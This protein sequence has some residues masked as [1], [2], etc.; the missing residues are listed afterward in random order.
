MS[1]AI[2]ISQHLILGHIDQAD[3][4][5][6]NIPQWPKLTPAVKSRSQRLLGLVSRCRASDKYAFI[7]TNQCG[8]NDSTTPSQPVSLYL[9][10]KQW[11]DSVELKEGL[12]VTFELRRQRGKSRHAAINV[13]A[14]APGFDDYQ[15][16]M[17][18]LTKFNAIEGSINRTYFHESISKLPQ[19][20]SLAVASIR[21]TILED[22]YNCQCVDANLWD[23]LLAN[24]PEDEIASFKFDSSRIKVIPPAL[25]ITLYKYC[26]DCDL[27]KNDAIISALTSAD[28]ASRIPIASFEKLFEAPEDKQDWAAYVAKS[29][30][31]S[32]SLRSAL[33]LFSLCPAVISTVKDRATFVAGISET[34]GSIIKLI[35]A[36]I[37]NEDSDALSILCGI[38]DSRMAD[39]LSGFNRVRLFRF[40]NALPIPIAAKYCSDKLLADI[41]LKRKLL[42]SDKGRE[43]LVERLYQM[44]SQDVS[45]WKLLLSAIEKSNSQFT[46][47]ESRIQPSAELRLCLYHH[48]HDLVWMSHPSI[49]EY[50][51]N[52]DSAD[53][54]S[55]VVDAF[56]N[57]KDYDQW[58][59]Y[60]ISSPLSNPT[61]LSQLFFKKCSATLYMAIEDKSVII[62]YFNKSKLKEWQA[63]IPFVFNNL[64][65]DEI[66]Q[67]C[68][69]LAFD[70]L[71]QALSKVPEA[72]CFQWI[73]KLSDDLAIKIATTP[74]FKGTSVFTN[75]IG[76]KWDSLKGQMEYIAFVLKSKDDNVEEFAFSCEDNIRPYKGDMQISALIRRLKKSPI[77]VGHNIKQHDLTLLRDR[78]L[79]L[80]DS[81]FIWDTLEMEIM[82]NPC[83]YAYS[84]QPQPEVE[85]DAKLV[86]DL[87]WNQLYRLS[88]DNE[89]VES[90][91]EVLPSSIN[92]ILTELRKDYF[93]SY[94]KQTANPDYK[95]FKE[96]KPLA[97]QTLTEL[98]AIADI[99]CDE[100]TLVI[101]PKSIWARLAQYIPLSFPS[102]KDPTM[103]LDIQKMQ[104]QPIN[105]EIKRTI[106]QRFCQVSKTPLHRNLAL[107]LRVPAKDGSP[108][109]I[110]LS[111]DFLQPY[112]SVFHSHIDCVDVTGFECPAVLGKQYKHIYTIGSE[113]DDRVHKRCACSDESLQNLIQRHSKLIF[114]MAATNYAPVKGKEIEKL[115]IVMPHLAANVWTER[116]RN[117]LFAFFLNYHYKEYRA[118]FLSHFN[119]APKSIK[120]EF[121]NDDEHTHIY[122]AQFN[123]QRDAD[124]L[125]RLSAST[126]MRTKYWAV[127]MMIINKIHL[128]NPHAPIIYI[129]N[130]DDELEDLKKYATS[131]GFYIPPEGKGLNKIEYTEG[132]SNCLIIITKNEFGESIDSFRT[133]KVCCFVWDNMDIDRYMLMWDKLPFVDDIQEGADAERDDT[134]HRSTPRQCIHALWPIYQ[135]YCSLVMAN[136]S[137]TKCFIIDPY[138]DDYE[139]IAD[140]CHTQSFKVDPQESNILFEDALAAASNFFGDRKVEDAEID[141]PFA[142][143]LIRQSFID[144]FNWKPTQQ[145]ILPHIIKKES[146]CIISM[147]TGEGKSVCFQGPALFRTIT[148]GK[149][150]LVITPL[151]ALMQDQVENLHKHGFVTN[152]DYISG[153]RQ[154]PEVDNIYRKIR[155]GELALLFITPERF[156][157]KS[158]I[159]VLI[160]RMEMDGGLEY[161][162]FDEAHCISQWGQDFRPDYRNAVI[163]CSELRQRFSFMFA[164]FSATVTSQVEEDIRSFLPHIQRLGQS[165]EDYNPIRQH[166]DISFSLVTHND[167][168]RVLEISNIIE[169]Q[170]ID[171]A[172]SCMIVFC[173]THRQCEETADALNNLAQIAAPGSILSK[174]ADRIGFYHAG[175]DSDLRNDVYEQFKQ[176]PGVSPIYILCA[177]KAFGMG[178]DIPNVHYV[179]HFNPPSVLEDYLQEVGRAGRD[180]QMYKTAF[181]N[182]GHIPAICL[183]SVEDFKKL[184][185]LLVRGQMSWSN[186]TEAKDAIVNYIKKFQSLEQTKTTPV[187]V[188][189]DVWLRNPDK[190]NDITPSRLAFHWLEKIGC[191]R[192][193]YLSPAHI[194]VT[195]CDT[196]AQPTPGAH[197]VY[198]YI[199][200][201][202]QGKNCL[203]SINDIRSKL[204]MSMPRIM[205]SLIRLMQD[206]LIQ[207]NENVTCSI[208]RSRYCE[209][210]DMVEKNRN[211]YTLHIIF[212]GIR[213]LLSSCKYNE[214]RAIGQHERND[215]FH[216]LM[217]EVEF[218]VI[219]EGIKDNGNDKVKVY[220]PWKS[221]NDNPP[222]RA[223]L[224]Y[225]TFRK[226]IITRMGPQ[227][228]SILYYL[229]MVSYKI[230]RQDDEV[231]CLITVKND[232]WADYLKELEQDCFQL[233]K[234]VNTNVVTLNW[235]QT[236]ID[237]G[238]TFEKSHKG[239]RYFEDVLSILQLLRYIDHSSL[240]KG[241][242]EILA[243][244]TTG[245]PI[246]EGTDEQ[247]P[248]HDHRKEFDSQ[249]QLRK[250]RLACMNI[251]SSVGAK[252]QGDYIRRYFQ[253]RNFEDYLK[254]AGDFLPENSSILSEV[255]EEALKDEE[256]KMDNN[257]QQKA[258]YNQP[259]DANVNVLAGPGSGKTY[260]L[261]LRCLKLIYK[262]HVD[263]SH[264]LVLAYNRAVV[265]ELRNRLNALFIRLGMSRSAYQLHVY[266]FHALAKK[267]L[268]KQ[269]DNVLTDKWEEKFLKHLT[270]K[271]A[272]FIAHFSNIAFVL[273]DEFQDITNV[274]LATL[275]RLHEIFNKAKFFTIGDINQSIYGFDRIP[276]DYNGRRASLQ[277]E[278]Y[279]QLLQ[280]QPYYDRWDELIKPKQLT[281]STN[282]RSYQ[283]ILDKASK[284]ITEGEMPRSAESLMQY[285]PRQPYVFEIDNTVESDRLWY[286]EL[287]SII[288]WAIEE[289]KAVEGIEDVALQRHRH[290][291][292]IAVFFRTNNEVY[293]GYSMIKDRIPSGARIRIQGESIGELWREREIFYLINIL[294]KNPTKSI[295]LKNNKTCGGIKKF[296]ED[297]MNRFTAWEPFLLDIT[298]CLVLNYIDSIRSDSEV[299]TWQDMADYIKDVASR[300]DATQVYKIYESYRAERILQEPIINIVLT[301]MHKV[302][303][304]EFDV[305]VTTPSDAS[306]PLVKHRD[307]QEGEPP[308]SDDL[309]DIEEERRLMYVAYTRAK[310][311]LYIYKSH[312]EIALENNQIY[313]A[314]DNNALRF[315]EVDPGSDKYYLNFSVTSQWFEAV[316]PYILQ[317]VKRDDPV[318]VKRTSDGNCYIMHNGGAIG[319]L[320]SGSSIAKRATIER[321]TELAGFFISSVF[322]WKYDDTLRS[323]KPEY[324]RY[325]SAKAIQN[326][327]VYVVQIA[328]FGKPLNNNTNGSN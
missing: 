282:Y 71:L 255:T 247:S 51:A 11:K 159:E 97:P 162:I 172:N 171:F 107:Y 191:I 82:L 39:T 41:Y 120:W 35:N 254:L 42:D 155:S 312:R 253:S 113:L 321:V 65:D 199:I 229:P 289:N 294:E 208:V 167:E 205:D 101:A 184:K 189:F 136:N 296:L 140:S 92:D 9:D 178:M 281:M 14:L 137:D 185:D 100:D 160:Q 203:I 267:C 123:A 103:S 116:R 164:L 197:P 220:M 181:A 74:L 57:L 53:N 72:T 259:K 141:V 44:Q 213:Q 148:S 323:K 276:K 146:D 265:V 237:L 328:G 46:F 29:E 54:I 192:Q 45:E 293:R 78:G 20:K 196:A 260:V 52:A 10:K 310:K 246:P 324:A 236:I 175:L 302:K 33:Y 188:P 308:L 225:D 76:E 135:H 252:Y 283:A 163:K 298:Y 79:D 271:P 94:F 31:V 230:E 284:F 85:D 219:K 322:V 275:T 56:N 206:K 179:V 226:N 4:N 109:K 5:L 86:N 269:L 273:V 90:L 227:M 18:Y 30:L 149:L 96:L 234:L 156:R 287:P 326:G 129:V 305:V 320:S 127:Q 2:F 84:L 105:D 307:Y 49:I 64:S 61:L 122:F 68:E 218:D 104:A 317:K 47:D 304:L 297:A 214:E 194:D 222:E 170:T 173:R 139:D 157:V 151:R 134:V 272:D 193:R 313:T 325:W 303:G 299:H 257:P 286:T 147:P 268:G 27:L 126:P 6:S 215:I 150:S 16:W 91:Q 118:Q 274:R 132:R 128:T 119:V 231:I 277:P 143:D 264:I 38:D 244:N 70:K 158:F 81:T 239:Y 98:Q 195:I 21:E 110:T 80:P 186:L 93:E 1:T 300:D 165:A 212:Q 263:P 228:F 209:L 19:S 117:G 67:L 311:R 202:P 233:L 58:S 295:E 28:E 261:T 177:T 131:L 32:D 224:L 174:C 241:G 216:H 25:L 8:I 217:D 112:L 240:S 168:A 77:I 83:R 26:K 182:G 115:D 256:K 278:R 291:D 187:V 89:L 245:L 111:E 48:S 7:V 87:F 124:K 223:V 125:M 145:E 152:V 121:C 22:L 266:T 249:E 280:P 36:Y 63:F 235:A 183:A 34:E 288:D 327:Y 301:T 258:I 130:D 292:T 319:R 73:S 316:N 15:V 285:Q 23:G 210:M 270:A 166:I 161:V 99:P 306:L 207:V 40:V 250:I 133:D 55:R 17:K 180:E 251:F 88:L 309:A 59:Q 243:T 238:W 13:R 318:I 102:E 114:A 198:K 314:P 62:N 154:R 201:Q 95:F 142:M 69:Q 12:W 315:T 144:G 204:H 108:Q 262:E 190:V 200:G 242:V 60:V 176:V 75:Y 169:Q 106:L 153:D 37:E 43:I 3:L 50:I 24:M 138:L 290:I 211:H 221:G 279:A 66:N 248:M 232:S